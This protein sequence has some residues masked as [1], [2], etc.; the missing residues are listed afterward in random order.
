M[1]Y[2]LFALALFVTFAPLTTNA[3]FEF[4]Q[5]VPAECKC[6]SVAVEGGS[7]ERTASAPAYGC[8]LQTIQNVIRVGIAIAIVVATLALIYAGFVWM[9][10]GTNPERRNQG[11]H[12]LLNVFVGLFVI[13]GAWLFVDFVMKSLAGEETG[14]FGPW[15]DI[16]G[17]D[18]ESANY[19]LVAR[20]PSPIATGTVGLNT[21]EPGTSS[22]PGGVT[23][24]VQG[25]R[26]CP[27]CVPLTGFQCK[28]ANSCT[29]DPAVR[30]RL[31]ALVRSFNGTWIVTEAYPPTARHSNQCHY[32]GTC[33]DAGFRG[34]TTYSAENVAA[35]AQAASRAGLRPVFETTDCRLRDAAIRA[36]VRAYCRSDSGYS[37]ITGNHFSLYSN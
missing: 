23:D 9:T 24:P 6:D 20:N 18:G 13:L 11:S 15:N 4:V 29:I 35:F 37:H 7:G 32:N 10:S 33:I 19:C 36:G 21:V 2:I 12:L 30:D 27:T 17:P 26:G 1:R 22:T 5:I 31:T 8:V 16:L 14:G 28:N 34:S 3:A 25:T